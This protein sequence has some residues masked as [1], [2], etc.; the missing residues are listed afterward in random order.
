MPKN[1]T[2]LEDNTELFKD[3]LKRAILRALERCGSQAEGYAKDLCPISDT[4]E[5]TLQQSITHKIDQKNNEV[6]VGTNVEYGAYVELGTGKYYPGGRPTPW[7]Y[8]DEN[9]DWHHTEGQEA[10]PYLVPAAK[11]HAQTYR[12]IFKEELG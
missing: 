4:G 10:Q 7:N 2:I 11:D 12:N 1:M 3:E 9:G 8:E 6:Y 5:K